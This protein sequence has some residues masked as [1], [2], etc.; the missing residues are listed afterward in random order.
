MAA[1]AAALKQVTPG[2]MVLGPALA[3]V[4]AYQAIVA[5]FP[6]GTTLG[7]IWYS[8]PGPLQP[9]RRATCLASRSMFAP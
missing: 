6:F 2:A 3:S 7:G 1:G 9:A 8:F 4:I 5:S